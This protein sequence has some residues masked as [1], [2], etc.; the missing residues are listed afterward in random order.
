MRDCETKNRTF[1]LEGFEFL[2]TNPT[3]AAK[4]AFTHI[5]KMRNGEEE[6]FECIFSLIDK[7]T[8]V[9]YHFQG[10]RKLLDKP[11]IL[12]YG[13]KEISVRFKNVVER[14]RKDE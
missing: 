6:N 5:T 11:M 2:G 4:R 9:V 8:N 14:I 7:D 10:R 1:T 3:N 12:Q 13:D